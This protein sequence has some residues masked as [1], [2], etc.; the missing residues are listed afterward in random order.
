MVGKINGTINGQKIDSELQGYVYIEDGRIHN[1]LYNM[2]LTHSNLQQLTPLFNTINWLFGTVHR[3]S[4]PIDNGF[5][6]TGGVVNRSAL[7]RIYENDNATEQSILNIEQYFR[8]I[9]SGVLHVDTY[10]NGSLPQPEGNLSVT[11]GNNNIKYI[12]RSLGSSRHDLPS[13]L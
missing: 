6:L 8:G 13:H 5:A 9:E 2:P 7:V 11:I 12:K 4:D 3:F 1:S 10:I